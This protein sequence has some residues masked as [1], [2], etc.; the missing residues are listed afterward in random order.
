MWEE[1]E[2]AAAASR[3]SSDLVPGGSRT[4]QRPT[5]ARFFPRS[6]AISR[7]WLSASLFAAADHHRLR[8]RCST[9]RTPVIKPNDDR[10][11]LSCKRRFSFLRSWIAFPG[12]KRIRTMLRGTSDVKIDLTTDFAG[13]VM[14]QLQRQLMGVFP[15]DTDD[16]VDTQERFDGNGQIT[17]LLFVLFIFFS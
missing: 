14:D 2:G 16:Q 13:S 17:L 12:S 7:S 3:Q 11:H 10:V 15:G 8:R 9:T 5:V 4:L 6:S 1:G